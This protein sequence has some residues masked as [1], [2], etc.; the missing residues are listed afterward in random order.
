ME[1]KCP[2]CQ[3]VNKTKF[4][5]CKGCEEESTIEEVIFD[6]GQKIS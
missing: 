2:H 3:K 1:K 6:K 5:L 4:L